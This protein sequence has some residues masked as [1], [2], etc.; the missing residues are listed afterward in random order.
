MMR[1]PLSEGGD[2]LQTLFSAPRTSHLSYRTKALGDVLYCVD[3]WLLPQSIGHS[4]PPSEPKSSIPLA[5]I[6]AIAFG[7]RRNFRRAVMPS[8]CGASAG[9]PATKTV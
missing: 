5:L 2:P 7:L 1:L 8:D 3:I 9:T 6:T 4:E